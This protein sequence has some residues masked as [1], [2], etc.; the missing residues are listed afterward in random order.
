M[1]NRWVV[2]VVDDALE[3]RKT[4]RRY[5]EESPDNLLCSIIEA[6]SGES[7]L[8]LYKEHLPDCVV[9]DYYLPD[10]DGLELLKLFK[11][12]DAGKPAGIVMLTGAGDTSI[13]V[14]AMKHGAHDYLDKDSVT[15][16]QLR[17]AVANAIEK[18]ILQVSLAQEREWLRATLASIGEGIIA[19]DFAGWVLFMNEIASELTG[20]SAEEA[21][22]RALDEVFHAVNATTGRRVQFP[23]LHGYG[24]T[25]ARID[26]PVLIGVDDREIP[27]EINSTPIR[28]NLRDRFGMVMVFRDV[29]ARL[30][31]ERTLFEQKERLRITLASIGDAVITTD[32]EARIESMNAKAEQLTGWRSAEALGRP[33]A[34]IF[35]IIEPDDDTAI[36]PAVRCIKERQVVQLSD[37]ALLKCRDGRKITVDD[38]AGPILDGDGNVVGAVVVFRDVTE[39]KRLTQE[40]SYQASHDMLTGLVNRTE[41][42]RRLHLLLQSAKHQRRSHALYYL[43]LDQF[44]IVN[45]TCGHVA[46]DELLRQLASIIKTT[47]RDRDTFARLGGDEFAILLGDCP[48][49]K[50]LR[51]ATDIRD[52]VRDFRFVWEEKRFS[53]GVSIGMVI[54]DEFS[55]SAAALLSDVD[56]ACYAAKEAGGNC[57]HTFTSKDRSLESR[58]QGEIEW[59]GRFQ[60]ALQENSFCLY[61]QDIKAV[62]G[63]GEGIAYCE[64]LLRLGDRS[65]DLLL[66][67]AFLP[68]AERYKQMLSIDR[69][70]VQSALRHISAASGAAG[71]KRYGV[72]IS[73]QS[74]SSADF[75]AFVM[76]MLETYG[77]SPERICFEFTET[78]AIANLSASVRFI[79]RLK[80]RGCTFALDSFGN[81]LSSFSYLKNLPVDYLKIDSGVVKDLHCDPVDCAMVEA[82]HRIGKLMGFATIAEGVETTMTLE[83][84]KAIGVDY[85]QGYEVAAPR[86]LTTCSRSSV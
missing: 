79:T 14:Q 34:E 80:E 48:Y 66:P 84:V 58:G 12:S 35:R 5:L 62:N 33:V 25:F 45:D 27:I 46:G 7:A 81:A 20:W 43:D 57:V 16:T 6:A 71:G 61:Q 26:K 3:D 31:H 21:K 2:M 42:E 76:Q 54:I 60:R 38:T 73:G 41:F 9:L 19:T 30:Q 72:N 75:L 36:N 78:A 22:G 51:I 70:V 67:G 68:A 40:I 82:I 50:A 18:V 83:K 56:N 59:V 17:R 86:P 29:S 53:L 64:C 85:V 4:Y 13:A 65:D 32:T 47:M 69:W 74:L 15:P 37:D 44:K 1:S 49:E 8:T 24:D 63:D 23:Q 52:I 39:Q 11:Q 55:S 28:N 10:H 77:V